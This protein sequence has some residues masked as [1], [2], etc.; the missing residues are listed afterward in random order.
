MSS[1]LHK[2]LDKM[3]QLE[4]SKPGVNKEIEG[5]VKLSTAFQEAAKSPA[6]FQLASCP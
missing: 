3:N 6:A 2:D 4:E 5:N 1:L